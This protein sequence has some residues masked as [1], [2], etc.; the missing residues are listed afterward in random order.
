MSASIY[1]WIALIQKLEL[2]KS[3]TI[4]NLRV[5]NFRIDGCNNDKV[6]QAFEVG[7]KAKYNVHPK[8]Q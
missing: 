1:S 4:V 2:R 5:A 7:N 8:R 6:T 3:L